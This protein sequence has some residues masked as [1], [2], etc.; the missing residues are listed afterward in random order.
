MKMLEGRTKVVSTFVIQDLQER[1][2][3]HMQGRC[4]GIISTQEC[5]HNSY[6]DGHTK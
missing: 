4:G 6:H 3:V 5:L 2:R 1:E